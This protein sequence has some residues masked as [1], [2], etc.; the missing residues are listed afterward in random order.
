LAGKYLKA[1]QLAKEI[2]KKAKKTAEKKKKAKEG[3]KKA[4]ELLEVSE[5]LG[6]DIS[7]TIGIIN[8][9]RE[10]FEDKKFEESSEMI[11]KGLDTLQDSY[12]DKLD[13]L[14][15]EI[16][17]LH[18]YLDEN[19]EETDFNGMINEVNQY[20][21]ESRYKEA[22]N[23]AEQI[24]SQVRRDV[25]ELFEERLL[26]LESK[27]K[28]LNSLDG[29][30]E[31]FKR[32]LAKAE[33]F[34]DE[35]EIEEAKNALS[36]LENNIDK[37]I[38]IKID[39]KLNEI[40][41][42]EELLRK[43]GISTE[44][45][46]ETVSEV[47]VKSK[48]GDFSDVLDLFGKTERELSDRKDQ[49]VTKMVNKLR[50]EIE[51][52]RDLGA[53]QK[54]INDIN[55][56]IDELQE[57]EDFGKIISLIDE[58][59]E[60]VEEA[61][62]HKVLKTI[63]ESRENFIKAKEMGIDIN[64][65]MT[66]LNKARTALKNGD[67]K[68][69]LN[70][71]KKGREKVR[72]MVKEHEKTENAIDKVKKLR[73]GLTEFDVDLAIIDDKIR[74]AEEYL[75]Q[76]EYS[77]S[78]DIVKEMENDIDKRAYEKIMEY[79]EEFEVHILTLE[80]M[81]LDS[82]QYTEM[83]EEAI[84]NTKTMDY[85]QAGKIALQGKDE[86][87]DKIETEL[88]YKIENISD[89]VS[90]IKNTMEIEDIEE[91]IGNVEEL[92]DE[93]KKEKE[94]D[95]YKIS[96]DKLKKAEEKIKDW[97]I[98][99]ADQKYTD[100]K[101]TLGLLGEI[102]FK[103]IS[104][105]DYQVKLEDAKLDIENGNYPSGIKKI[106]NILGDLNHKLKQNSEDF[107]SKAKVEVVKAK[108]S[109]VDIKRMREEL[110]ECKKYIK[111]KNY[112]EAIRLSVDVEEKAKKIR[113]ARSQTKKIISDLKNNIKIA[114]EELEDEKDIQPVI[115]LF[116]ESKKSFQKRNYIEAKELANKTEM[117]IDELKKKMEFE[118]Y[119][120]QYE[121]LL[122]RAD[123]ISVDTEDIQDQINTVLNKTEENDYDTAIEMISQINEDILEEIKLSVKPRLNHTQEIIESAKE[124]GIDIT[125]QEVL[126]DEAKNDFEN[127]DFQ[128]TVE[129]IIECQNQ[130][131][132]IKDKSKKAARSVKKAK[133]R[134]E[135]A[136]DLHADVSTAK[137]E[138]Q[139]S[140]D[141]IK[142]DEYEKAIEMAEKALSSIRLAEKNRVE[143][144]LSTF[145]EK[146]N[147]M[148]LDGVNTSLADN[149]IARAEKAKKNENYKEAINLA[150]QSEGELERIELQQDIAKRS[151]STT[152]NK[153]S[154]AKEKGIDVSKPERILNQAKKSYEEGFY[155]KAFDKAVKSGELLNNNVKAFKESKAILEDVEKVIE[156]I[157]ELNME[158]KGLEDKYLKA[159]NAFDD[160]NYE[161]S[162][163]LANRA[164]EELTNLK[165]DLPDLISEMK[166]AIVELKSKGSN[167]GKSEKF[168]NKAKANLKMGNT[169]EVFDNLVKANEEFGGKY[170]KEYE[171]YIDEATDLVEKASK[172]GTDV[173][174]TKNIIK[175]ARKI[176]ENDLKK[177]CLKA[178]EAVVDIEK[179][180]APYSPC[181][182]VQMKDKLRIDKWNK[183][184][185]VIKNT[186]GGVAKSPSVEII[187]AKNN[188]I[189]MPSMLKANESFE[190]K[191]KVKPTEDK[192]IIK[193]IGTRIFDN[194]PISSEIEVEAI[195]GDFKII[196]SSG[197]EKCGICKGEVKKGLDVII[198]DCGSSYHKLCGERKEECPDCGLEFTLKEKK[199]EEKKDKK[200]S[201]RVA[202]RI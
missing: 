150:M 54:S 154:K 118:E 107:F 75:E 84:A 161:K 158:S 165:K 130:I 96:Y 57:K 151:I 157:N 66:I 115:S 11:N 97:Q 114:K 20:F 98:G 58:L 162:F 94:K 103:D 129:K 36:S 100:A 91:D 43:N 22:I 65:P 106:E 122:S 25:E 61:K 55:D 53:P 37:V 77:K 175:E 179:T 5:E 12:S 78:R 149:L 136:M 76:K 198:C 189:K 52:A 92:I 143:K 6:I 47:K 195:E 104:I 68:E 13:E 117:K 7:D 9:A 144:I 39:N 147:E 167:V 95:N 116:K 8:D 180:L 21:E 145:K 140:M 186:G 127:S 111:Q 33:E 166:D 14:I 85:I 153:L 18:N 120:S 201:K 170:L 73:E 182:E 194:K 60:K 184:N 4:E 35:Y 41:K 172:F 185:L 187:G 31:E 59:F 62:F 70:W 196:K 134:L 87:L 50:D 82:G 48:N 200:A 125:Q 113:E 190:T 176:K 169:L 2:E 63:A 131:Q 181:I 191:T 81:G 202:L 67:H 119:Y 29:D 51:K 15:D 19:L 34:L 171:R 142:N 80:R 10:N 138:L 38:Q 90:N 110:I 28:I 177:A 164:K 109:G 178:K 44:G 72:D 124:I 24:L 93:G 112:T 123:D 173:S 32:E 128:G 30:T 199:K 139:H 159:R 101:E 197:D 193:G 141:A 17:S 102:D 79:I 183:I 152:S 126:L 86:I 163:S 64:E 1:R 89:I 49:L 192:V 71:A 23:K 108:K 83:L 99:E 137:R 132:Q 160:D 16:K 156:R 168:I 135:E 105:E 40:E 148:R 27:I 174:K 188:D 69:A 121:D 155:V 133:N 146:I 88:E 74:E 26:S 56:K 45:I 3:L 42:I 46:E